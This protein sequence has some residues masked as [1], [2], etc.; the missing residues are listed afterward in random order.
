MILVGRTDLSSQYLYSSK[1]DWFA[2]Q[3]GIPSARTRT[4]VISWLPVAHALTNGSCHLFGKGTTISLII[5]IVI[6]FFINNTTKHP[7]HSGEARGAD[8]GI[9]FQ[10]ST[11]NALNCS[12][13][14]K[15]YVL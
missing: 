5:S 13:L 4:A 9:I 11:I 7:G 2:L 1:K 3:E 10:L 12:Q 14:I 6:E 8:T 15:K